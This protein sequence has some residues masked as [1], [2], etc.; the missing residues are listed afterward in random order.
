MSLHASCTY[1]IVTYIAVVFFYSCNVVD[2]TSNY[3]VNPYTFGYPNTYPNF[4]LPNYPNGPSVN[5]PSADYVDTWKYPSSSVTSPTENTL[6]PKRGFQEMFINIISYV[7]SKFA[8]N[9]SKYAFQIIEWL[10][11]RFS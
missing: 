6:L 3:H 9:I 1:A 8:E 4:V 7:L 5:A 10:I 11:K 2:T